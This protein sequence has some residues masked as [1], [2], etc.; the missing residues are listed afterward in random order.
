MRP[1]ASC[2]HVKLVFS[3][4]SYRDRTLFPFQTLEDEEKFN[5]FATRTTHGALALLLDTHTLLFQLLFPQ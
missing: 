1:P 5:K 4:Y 2:N 3:D